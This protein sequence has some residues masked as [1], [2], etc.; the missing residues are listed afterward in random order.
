MRHEWQK[1]HAHRVLAGK[2]T[3]RENLE[4]LGMGG[5]TKFKRNVQI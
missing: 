4:E 3:S 1:R 5:K 2:F